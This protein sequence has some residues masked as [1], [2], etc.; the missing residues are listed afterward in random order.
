MFL[1]LLYIKK[2]ILAE[3]YSKESV[4]QNIKF[5]QLNNFVL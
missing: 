2:K 4:Y 5:K 1:M 3:G